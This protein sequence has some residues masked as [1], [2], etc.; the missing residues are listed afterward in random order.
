MTRAQQGKVPVLACVAVAYRF[1]RDNALQLVSPCLVVAAGSG[2]AAL[3]SYPSAALGAP[4]GSP[5][6][7]STLQF[8]VSTALNTVTGVVLAGAV[9]RK[10]IRGETQGPG[11][12]SFG[13][14]E[15]RLL[16]STLAFM[17]IFA[18]L[19]AA[20]TLLGS[21]LVTGTPALSPEAFL[22]ATDFE[23]MEDRLPQET[24][25]MLAAAIL[26]CFGLVLYVGVRL[27]LINAAAVGERKI[28]ILQTWSWT[29]GNLW[30]VLGAVVMTT[31]PAMLVSGFL[32]TL[33]A[34]AAQAL[35]E[36][37]A[38]G[39]LLFLAGAIEGF[40]GALA[41]IPLLAL[42]AELYKGLRPPGF[43]PR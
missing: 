31:I 11:G 22:A 12:V 18:P 7:D 33:L 41:N 38:N 6:A 3:V 23:G 40:V 32:L 15:V 20:Y 43:A 2:V 4:A 21:A 25:A 16:G 29:Q 1:F 19:L 5:A 9:F 24:Q 42:S 10:S 8:L 17:L 35:P 34:E 14:D 30:R 28:V 27:A 13:A 39:P 36:V 26:V 37:A